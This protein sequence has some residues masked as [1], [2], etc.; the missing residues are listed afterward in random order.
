M[1]ALLAKLHKWTESAMFFDGTGIGKS[2]IASKS[3]KILLIPLSSTY[4]YHH[5]LPNYSH[6]ITP[7]IP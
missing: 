7:N 6:P 5:H 4:R 1:L 2:P 3:L